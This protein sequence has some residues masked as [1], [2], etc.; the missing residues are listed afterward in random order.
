MSSYEPDVGTKLCLLCSWPSFFEPI[1]PEHV[2]AVKDN[3]IPFVPRT[4]V[5]CARSGAHLGHVFSDGM[6]LSWAWVC[7]G[8]ISCRIEPH[9]LACWLGQVAPA[10]RL[11]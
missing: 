1:D 11:A 2:I 6:L 3:S 8:A 10:S 4:E 7:V 9:L 5:V